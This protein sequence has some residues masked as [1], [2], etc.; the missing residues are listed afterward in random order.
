MYR[1]FCSVRCIVAPR[2]SITHTPIRKP[3]TMFFIP[4]RFI[5]ML[6]CSIK[7]GQHVLRARPSNQQLLTDPAFVVSV[8]FVSLNDVPTTL[9]YNLR[10]KEHLRLQDNKKRW[11]ITPAV[12]SALCMHKEN[13]RGEYTACRHTPRDEPSSDLRRLQES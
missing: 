11:T 3:I 2:A 1:P 8:V 6:L 12:F 7:T 9:A 5:I 13:P 4:S 10:S